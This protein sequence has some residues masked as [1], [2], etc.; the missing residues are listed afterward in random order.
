MAKAQMSG[1]GFEGTKQMTLLSAYYIAQLS[2]TLLADL[3][4]CSREQQGRAAIH[5]ATRDSSYQYEY[6]FRVTVYPLY[7]IEKTLTFLLL[8]LVGVGGGGGGGRKEKMFPTGSVRIHLCPTALPSHRIY[9][10]NFS[11]PC[12]VW[13]NAHGHRLVR[14]QGYTGMHTDTHG[15]TDAHIHVHPRK[16]ADTPSADMR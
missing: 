15:Y 9:N 4:I 7:W 11:P 2:T 16:I 6:P 10:I 12:N 1:L 8:L 3:R 14:R 13:E 5:L